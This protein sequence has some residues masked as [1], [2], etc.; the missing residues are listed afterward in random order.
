MYDD[1]FA[2]SINKEEE[3]DMFLDGVRFIQ[4]INEVINM[5]PEEASAEVLRRAENRTKLENSGVGID[6]LVMS[7]DGK[8]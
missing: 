8:A 5:F 1:E 6:I 3:M 2:E 7:F 4:D